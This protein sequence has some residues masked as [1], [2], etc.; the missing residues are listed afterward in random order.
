MLKNKQ[1]IKNNEIYKIKP[2]KLKQIIDTC[3]LKNV[4]NLEHSTLFSELGDVFNL[5][6][7]VKNKKTIKPF[8]IINK[9]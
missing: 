3:Y 7:Y 6:D 1:I 9:Y 8:I 4:N 2:K 5:Y